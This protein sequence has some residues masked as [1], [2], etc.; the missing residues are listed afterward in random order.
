MY[1]VTSFNG[2]DWSA[3]KT[4]LS[5]SSDPISVGNLTSDYYTYPFAPNTNYDFERGLVSQVEEFTQTGQR[6]SMVTNNYTRF[7]SALRV[8][9]IRYDKLNAT[10]NTYGQYEMITNVRNVLLNS[11][12]STYDSADQ[13]K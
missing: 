7:G 13:T 9:A 6:V 2:T 10:I 11:T 1:N 3:T 4:K 12:T 5:K 8:K